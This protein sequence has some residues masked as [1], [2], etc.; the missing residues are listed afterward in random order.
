MIRRVTP[1]RCV[2]VA[3]SIA[4]LLTS[5][6]SDRSPTGSVED[7]RESIDE[8]LQRS[9]DSTEQQAE[10]E[11]VG[12]ALGADLSQ[13]ISQS[14][15]DAAEW[16][17]KVGSGTARCVGIEGGFTA[18]L[19]QSSDSSSWY[20]INPSADRFSSQMGWAVLDLLPEIINTDIDSVNPYDL[21]E[22]VLD[23]C[24]RAAE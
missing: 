18:S 13:P 8:G 20:S 2:L 7:A 3:A 12:F 5:C 16:P 24:R 22:E 14:E 1:N 17:F 21:N 23:P 19:F 4:I 10:S 6:G 9:D 15:F 11:L